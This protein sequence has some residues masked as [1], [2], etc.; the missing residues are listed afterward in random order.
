MV[1]TRNLDALATALMELT[2]CLN[3]PRQDDVL[4]REAGVTL[5]RA[6]FPLLVRLHTAAPLPVAALAEQVGRDAS[7]VSRQ[8]AKLQADGLIERTRLPEDQR[9]RAAAI[10]AQGIDTL[11]AITRARRRL[12]NEALSDWT[13]QERASFPQLAL[14]LASA[15]KARVD[16]DRR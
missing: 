1:D 3:S 5:D 14:R 10:T 9:T 12:L 8:L 13:A 6:L 2:G 16:A 7:T 4:L 11:K 15:M